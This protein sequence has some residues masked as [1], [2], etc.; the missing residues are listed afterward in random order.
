MS[1]KK[2]YSVPVFKGFSMVR[3]VRD[4]RMGHVICEDK[5]CHG[6]QV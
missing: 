2:L 1:L 4:S 5:M 3:R 6:V